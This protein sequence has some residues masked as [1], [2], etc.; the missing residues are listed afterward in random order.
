[1]RRTLVLLLLATVCGALASWIAYRQVTLPAPTQTGPKTV[2]VVVA[3]FDMPYGDAVEAAKLKLVAWPEES[4][5]E[6]V[7]TKFEDAIGKLA[8]TQILK[9]EPITDRRVAD[10]LG[11]SALANLIE[12]DK[13][14]MTVRVNDVIGVGGFLLPGNRVDVLAT[15][16]V[17][18][19]DGQRAETRTILKNLKVLAVDQQ[20]RTD[21]DD[22]VVVRA[23]TVEVDPKQ[24]ELLTEATQEGPVQLV[25]R[26]PMD[27]DVAGEPEPPPPAPV[28][29]KRKTEP[30]KLAPPPPPPEPVED[31]YTT[32]VTV[33]R[34]TSEGTS[35][36]Q[37]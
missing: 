24:A 4:L 7:Y 22:P 9:G 14:A 28:V 17:R 30:K 23:V 10:N 12:K 18:G 36:A 2:P 15:R 35:K 3:A 20:A 31:P 25:L 19:D 11:G 37:K 1:M 27:A 13:R 29:A 26:N 33:I 32:P 6:G 5:P 16:R 21:K 8:T 34:G